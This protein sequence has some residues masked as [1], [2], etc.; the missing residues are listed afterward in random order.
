MADGFKVLLVNPPFL[1]QH[2]RYSRYNRSPGITKSGT[3]YYPLWIA[4]AAGVLE[5][6]GFEVKLIDCPAQCIDLNG[7]LEI[8]EGFKP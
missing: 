5:R 2:G 7:L 8:A 1:P 6:A 4:F 3:L